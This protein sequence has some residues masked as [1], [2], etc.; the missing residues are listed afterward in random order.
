MADWARTF[1]RELPMTIRRWRLVYGEY[2]TLVAVRGRPYA[3]V[4]TKHGTQLVSQHVPRIG[5]VADVQ[6]FSDVAATTKLAF[7]P[8]FAA[9][10]GHAS[11]GPIL[12]S[13]SEG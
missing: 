1:D 8:S 7:S 6:V 9:T 5:R 11:S 13:V 4:C 3:C 10:C 12:M 2:R